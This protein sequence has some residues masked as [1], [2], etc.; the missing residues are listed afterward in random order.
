MINK[1]A[2]RAKE[3]IIKITNALHESGRASRFYPFAGICAVFT[4]YLKIFYATRAWETLYRKKTTYYILN[5]GRTINDNFFHMM[6]E[7]VPLS[8]FLSL[9]SLALGWV[10][11]DRLK[12]KS[13]RDNYTSNIRS[14]QWRWPYKM[15]F[16]ERAMLIN[17]LYRLSNQ[18]Y[19]L[20]SSYWRRRSC[21][22]E[23]NL[24]ASRV[25]RTTR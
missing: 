14:F 12:D 4:L 9:S 21:K 20:I 24:S 8:L 7:K 19:L 2:G 3:G 11:L 16:R 22:H 5:Y 13:R 15:S 6:Q 10:Y 1:N 25:A 23:S 18:M 17:E